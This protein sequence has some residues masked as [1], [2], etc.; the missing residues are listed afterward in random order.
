LEFAYLPLGRV[1]GAWNFL[2]R[3]TR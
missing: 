1:F 3:S 2:V